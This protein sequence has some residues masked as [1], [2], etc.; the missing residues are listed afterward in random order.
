MATRPRLSPQQAADKLNAWMRPG[1]GLERVWQDLLM[2]ADTTIAARSIRSWMRDV[3]AAAGPRSPSD[4]GPLRMVGGALA[5]AVGGGGFN[6]R[7]KVA[8]ISVRGLRASLEKGGDLSV[9][10]YF[11][12]H[13]LGGQAGVNLSV[14][15]PARPFIRPAAHQEIPKIARHGGKLAADSLRQA[16]RV[17]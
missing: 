1:G 13:E 8:R 14:T 12:I 17:I 2:F 15:I 4:A 5:G 16:F 7:G 11:R 6:R 9:V 10:P 3:G